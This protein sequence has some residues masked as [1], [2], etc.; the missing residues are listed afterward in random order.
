MRKLCNSHE[1]QTP[2]GWTLSVQRALIQLLVLLIVIQALSFF[3]F[4]II[5]I[6][7]IINICLVF[8]FSNYE[9]TLQRRTVMRA[10]LQP[11]KMRCRGDSPH[12]SS[13]WRPEVG[14]RQSLHGHNCG[15]PQHF[16]AKQCSWHNC[17][18]WHG[19]R[20]SLCPVACTFGQPIL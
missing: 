14:H 16:K 20:E 4:F 10:S 3:F 9:S 19:S 13:R 1:C 7:I 17:G 12:C 6:V 11:E 5:V 2:G 8:C 15:K 18:I